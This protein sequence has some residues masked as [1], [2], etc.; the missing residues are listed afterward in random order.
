[1][2]RARSF[3]RAAA[4]TSRP[5]SRSGSNQRSPSNN[6]AQMEDSW[7]SQL[8]RPASRT[9]VDSRRFEDI[10]KVHKTDWEQRIRGS[11][12]SLPTR[13]PPP[14]RREINM[15]RPADTSTP[16][17]PPPPT[18]ATYPPNSIRDAETEFPPPP[19]SE[20]S[21]KLSEESV[22]QISEENKEN[23]VK[24][25][26]ESTTKSAEEIAKELEKFA[27]DIAETVV[28]NMEKSPEK[29]VSRVTVLS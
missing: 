22:G 24:Q 1:M 21:S 15:K 8:E 18:R 26:V 4:E 11:V 19:V 12:E 29:K 20:S 27:Y 7:L 9:D 13:T 2:E 28:S 5:A 3:E 10:G 6:R 17:P 14:R 25:W 16:E 23:I